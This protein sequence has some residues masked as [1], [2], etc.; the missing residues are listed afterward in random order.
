MRFVAPQVH[1]ESGEAVAPGPAAGTRVHDPSDLNANPLQAFATFAFLV[2]TLFTAA[3]TRLPHYIAPAYPALSVLTA[4]LIAHWLQERQSLARRFAVY[5]TSTAIFLYAVAALLT[6]KPRKAL[7]NPQLRDGYS[8][9][10]NRE[11]VALLQQLSLTN[12]PV[13]LGGARDTQ[14]KDLPGPLLVW[15]QTPVV[16]LTTDAFYAHR[17]A[18]QVTLALPP[19]NL[20][21]SPYFNQPQLLTPLLNTSHLLLLDRALLPDLP[22]NVEAIP[23]VTGPTQAIVVLRPRAS[24]SGVSPSIDPN[25]RV[26]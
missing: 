11:S 7:H 6:A 15:R 1:P 19:A 14:P 16:P 17:L 26:K 4:A 23:L 21:P 13:A 25:R 22:A 18:Q 2:L 5:L 10:D 9:P 3:S 20:P 8:T 24:S 12:A